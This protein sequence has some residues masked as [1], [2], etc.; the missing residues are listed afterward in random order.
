MTDITD[1]RDTIV[2]KSDQLNADQLLGGPMTLTITDV[3]RGSEDQPVVID[4]EGSNGRPYK[5]CKSMRKVL[6]YAWGEDGS[7][8]VGRSITVF[9]KPDVKWGGVAVGGI[10]ISHMTDIP[11]D[12]QLALAETKGK[13]SPFTV[14]R[15]D[16]SDEVKRTRGHLEGQA[17]GGMAALQ[18]A[19]KKVPSHI[20]RAFGGRGCPTDIKEIAQAAD[21]KATEQQQPQHDTLGALNQAAASGAPGAGGTF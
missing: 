7:K 5:P 17:R 21:A 11:S 13:K 12:L 19:W 14:K 20:K 4:Y 6:I 9:N 18:A 1:L 15:L 16:L 10:R 3:S 8:W 2:P